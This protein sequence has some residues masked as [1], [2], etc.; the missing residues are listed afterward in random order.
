MTCRRDQQRNVRWSE[1]LRG[2]QKRP[3]DGSESAAD[4]DPVATIPEFL[5]PNHARSHSVPPPGVSRHISNNP[6]IRFQVSRI[7]E[8][9]SWAEVR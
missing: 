5:E 1:F 7:P 8:I 4:I 2:F 9:D 3:D 6:L